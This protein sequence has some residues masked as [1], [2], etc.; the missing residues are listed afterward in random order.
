MAAFTGVQA[1]G[2][3]NQLWRSMPSIGRLPA[4]LPSASPSIT[5][6]VHRDPR[7]D[8]LQ[9]EGQAALTHSRTDV[10]RRS[11]PFAVESRWIFT[12]G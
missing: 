9:V 2:H 11:E 7:V 10:I 6:V 4:I 1:T 8:V 3:A 5:S 12:C